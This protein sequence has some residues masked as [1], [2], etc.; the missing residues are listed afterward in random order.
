QRGAQTNSS[1]LGPGHRM[2]CADLKTGRHLWERQIT[3][4]VISA[5]VISG[6]QVLFTCFDGVSFCLDASTGAVVWKKDNAGTSAPL[7]AD[8]H[9]LTTS[10]EMEDGKEY[11]GLKRLD[12]KEGKDR[13]R[14]MLARA[15]AGYLRAGGG[16]G[17]A[18]APKEVSKLDS[19]VGFSGGAPPAAKLSEANKH[20]GVNTVARAWAYQGSRAAYRNG[21]MMN[22]QGKYLNSIKAGD[23]KFTWRAEIKGKRIEGDTQVFSPPALG[24]R[25]LYLCGAQGHLVAVKQQ[26]GALA[27]AYALKQPM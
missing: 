21:Q 20:I 15:K 8:G 23:G 10:K 27:F 9:V 24:E 2:L 1:N 26:D 14:R 3:A 11:E 17:V 5:P 6:D 13:D 4:D 22:A 19:S 12:L 18:I 7:V 25:N 16:G